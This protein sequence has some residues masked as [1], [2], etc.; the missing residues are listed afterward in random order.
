M[1]WSSVLSAESNKWIIM[2][3]YSRHLSSVIRLI[4][5]ESK[6]WL[7][8]E[9]L[10]HDHATIDWDKKIALALFGEEGSG[11]SS[12]RGPMG[13]DLALFMILSLC[14]CWLQHL[15]S[16][17]LIKSRPACLESARSSVLRGHCRSDDGSAKLLKW[18]KIDL[19]SLIAAKHGFRSVF[20]SLKIK[21]FVRFWTRLP[22]WQLPL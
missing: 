11:L 19:S 10:S 21:N 16:S 1:A 9:D 20:L 13:E 12:L 8:Q 3:V 5:R 15:S 6:L 22:I 2:I 14:S 18:K 7:G 4:K 17:L